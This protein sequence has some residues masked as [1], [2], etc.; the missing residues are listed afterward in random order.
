MLKILAEIC[1]EGLEEAVWREFGRLVD[2]CTEVTIIPEPK[3][4]DRLNSKSWRCISLINT[5]S[6]FLEK[7]L[8][9]LIIARTEKKRILKEKQF[10]SRKG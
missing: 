6:K 8:T 1:I 4:M 3:K 5:T 9:N 2:T 7:I 10:G